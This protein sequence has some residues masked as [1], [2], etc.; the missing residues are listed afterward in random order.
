MTMGDLAASFSRGLPCPIK[1]R[2]LRHDLAEKAH[3]KGGRGI[4]GLAEKEWAKS[5]MLADQPRQLHEVNCRDQSDIDLRIT[6]GRGIAGND[7]VAGD[8]DRHA[9]GPH[10]AVDGSD[11]RLTHAILDIVEREIQ[12][13][14]KFLGLDSRLAPNDIQ[15][16]PGAKHLVRAAD[17]DGANCFVVPAFASAASSASISGMLSALTGGRSSMIS[18]IWPETE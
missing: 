8:R 9:A 12:P 6:E 17:D 4:E 13:F 5:L 16:E 10:R 15:I 2:S 1:R 18:A 14:E 11:G 3:A 7:H